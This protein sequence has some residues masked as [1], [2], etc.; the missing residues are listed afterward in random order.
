MRKL[1]SISGL[2]EAAEDGMLDGALGYIVCLLDTLAR[3][4]KA[5]RCRWFGHSYRRLTHSTW[6][7]HKCGRLKLLR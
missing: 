7:C 3:T 6:N 1:L 2:R 5:R 4:L